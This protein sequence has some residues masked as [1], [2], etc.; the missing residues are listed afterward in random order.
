[1]LVQMI[2]NDTTLF[3]VACFISYEILKAARLGLFSID[4]A[5]RERRAC[6]LL[7]RDLRLSHNRTVILLSLN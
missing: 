6:I 3:I 1:M 5:L 7:A 4:N 2:Q